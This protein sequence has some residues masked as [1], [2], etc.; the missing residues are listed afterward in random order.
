MRGYARQQTALPIPAGRGIE[1]RGTGRGRPVDSRRAGAS[2]SHRSGKGER[3][4]QL[5]RHYAR[6]TAFLIDRLT[7]ALNRVARAGD[8]QSIH[9]VRVHRRPIAVERESD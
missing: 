8:A 1:P 9:D 4:T 5:M 6:Q 2:P 7:A 3:V